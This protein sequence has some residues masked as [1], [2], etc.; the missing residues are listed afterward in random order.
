MIR[1]MAS[2]SSP[3]LEVSHEGDKF[4]IITKSAMMTKEWKVTVGEECEDTQKNGVV[5]KVFHFYTFT[6][7]HS[8]KVQGKFNNSHRKLSKFCVS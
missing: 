6:K 2:M 3:E 8:E 1:K 5:F 4:I 7:I